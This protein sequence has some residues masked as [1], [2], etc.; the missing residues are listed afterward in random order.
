MARIDTETGEILSDEGTE[1]TVQDRAKLALKGNVAQLA[2]LALESA[3]LTKIDTDENYKEIQVAK[4]KLVKMRLH[5]TEVGKLARDDA[6]AFAKAVIAE[7]KSLIEIIKPEELRLAALQFDWDEAIRIEKGKE[8][9]AGEAKRL[10]REAL[11]AS[12]DVGLNFGDNSAKISAR[13]EAVQAVNLD[14]TAVVL[15]AEDKT[16]LALK[17]LQ[18]LNTLRDALALATA[19]EN[20]M[21]A[22]QLLQA[23]N[24]QKLEEAERQ[25][26]AK[27]AAT[28]ALEN[29]PDAEK[30]DAWATAVRGLSFPIMESEVGQATKLEILAA[31]DKL[32]ARVSAATVA[33]R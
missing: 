16:A 4:T 28:R 27:E 25:A 26:K 19:A 21:A 1:L 18:S 15:T 11:S 24:Q 31:L 3:E 20:N 9:A 13:I 2:A 33:M 5:I 10:A 22:A 8:F 23:A 32:I 17:Q 12:V 6:N 7:E 14:T 30:I 29:A